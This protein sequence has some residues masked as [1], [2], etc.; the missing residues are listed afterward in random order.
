MS[1]P[2]EHLDRPHGMR[3]AVEG[4]VKAGANLSSRGHL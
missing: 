2:E 4:G 3:A 1:A